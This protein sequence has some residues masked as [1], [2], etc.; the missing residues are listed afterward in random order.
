MNLSYSHTVFL[1]NSF[2]LQCK[3]SLNIMLEWILTILTLLLW[4]SLS[5]PGLSL[6]MILTGPLPHNLW[7]TTGT[8]WRIKLKWCY[9]RF[10]TSPWNWPGSCSFLLL[11]YS[12]LEPRCHTVRKHKQLCGEVHV[13]NKE[14]RPLA[15]NPHQAWLTIWMTPFF[16]FFMFL[17]FFFLIYL[18]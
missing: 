1:V 12:F 6:F 3:S 8:L 7:T 10:G 13:E 4:R 18:F 16:F 14:L 15:K 11:E 5:E 17:S 2:L 9:A